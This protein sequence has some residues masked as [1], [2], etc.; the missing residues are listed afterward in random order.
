L[1]PFLKKAEVVLNMDSQ[2]YIS[3]LEEVLNQYELL[4][5]ERSPKRMSE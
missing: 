4:G 5:L 3:Q 1:N 2:E